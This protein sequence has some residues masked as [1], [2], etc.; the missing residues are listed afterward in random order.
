MQRELDSLEKWV[1]KNLLRFNKGKCK[2]LHF[3]RSNPRYA[4]RLGEELIESSPAQKDLMVV[5]HEKLDMSQQCVLAAQKVNCILGCI[6]SG[7]ASREREVIGGDC[8]P[9]LCSC[10]TSS[11]VLH[12]G[13]GPPV[14]ER[15]TAVGAVPEDGQDDD[16]RAGVP[17]L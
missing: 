17:P 10:E 2:V 5:V 9:L 3:C 12:P 15:Y 1:H 13:L 14:Q 8:T 16:Q 6:K 11:G 7:V 4:N